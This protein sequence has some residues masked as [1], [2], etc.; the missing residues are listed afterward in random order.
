[1]PGEAVLQAVSLNAS[2]YNGAAVIGPSLAGLLLVH[3]GVA[4]CFSLNALSFLV[5]VIALLLIDKKR[6]VLDR[7]HAGAKV[8]HVR[9]IRRLKTPGQ[10]RI[11][12]VVLTIAATVS[13]LGRPYLL[14][15][16][17]FARDVQ[18]VGAQGLGVMVAAS[19]LGSLVGAIFLAS[20]RSS[21]PLKPLLLLCCAEFGI[22]LT[23]FAGVPGFQVTLPL[24]FCCG[25]GATMTMMVANSW[26]QT[27]APP[28]IRGRIMSLYTLIAAGFSQLGALLISG[29]A[30]W[31]GLEHTMLLAGL[32][33]IF[34][35]LPGYLL[36]R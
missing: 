33:V 8:V 30:I 36:L 5:V 2:V 11:I 15:L 22:A 9:A 16:P 12:L 19:G 17:A 31:I 27:A 14:L 25:A 29:A 10:L 35:I 4:L 6:L 20:L 28:D 13:L 24:L 7:E 1:M 21:Q 3:V 26:L 18:R 23:L 34:V 32:G